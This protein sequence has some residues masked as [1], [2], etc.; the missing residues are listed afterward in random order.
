MRE[1]EF[2]AGG[3]WDRLREWQSISAQEAADNVLSVLDR[4]G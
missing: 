3:Y 2:T 1:L 4:Y